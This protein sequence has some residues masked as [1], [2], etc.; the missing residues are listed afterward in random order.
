MVKQDEKEIKNRSASL[1]G[2]NLVRKGEVFA[3][4]EGAF[5]KID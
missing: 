4:K 3:L 5:L 1:K 2:Y